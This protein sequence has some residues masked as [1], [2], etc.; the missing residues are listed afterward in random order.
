VL[1]GRDNSLRGVGKD[2]P[3][4]LGNPALSQGR[5][6]NDRL[7]QY[8]N[9]AM[10]MNATG[11]YGSAGRNILIGPGLAKVD[12][13]LGKKI[14]LWSERYKLE[15]RWDVFNATN[16]ANFGQPGNS[17]AATANFGRIT[18]AGAGR[19]MQLALRFEF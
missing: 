4:L 19:V 1:A 15:V 10:F 17:L 12:A 7:A 2:R 3:D 16:R 8:F 9:I 14:P 5:P 11:Q 18:S 13:S 6:L